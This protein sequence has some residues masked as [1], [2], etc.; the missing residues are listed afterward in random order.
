MGTEGM[1]FVHLHVHS[2]YS[3]M[4]GVSSPGAL[5]QA[6]KS[7]GLEVLA[8]TDT[9]GLYGLI[10]FLEA[11][12]R[13]GIRPV[14]GAHLKTR[15]QEAVVL[16]KTESGYPILSD[17]ISRI[18][19]QKDFLL[20]EGF[21]EAT[22]DLAVLS[23]DA[24]LLRSLRSKVE[25]WVEINPGPRGR[26]AMEV[27][28]ALQLPPLA[29]NAVYFAHPD[30][31]P[32]HRLVRA[33]DA[34]CT[35]STLPPH[36]TVQP[37]Q[38][39]KTPAEMANHLP[40]CPEAMANTARLASECQT[41]WDF[42]G[43]VFPIYEDRDEDHFQVLLEA[44]REG[45]R[46]RYGETGPAIEARLHEEL[47]LIRGKGYVDYFLVVADIVR[48]R[49]I[50]CGR[51]SGAASLV[52]YLLGITHVD[53]IRHHLL[54]GRFLNPQRKDPPDID[55][56]FPWDERDD[57][58]EE[59]R[60]HHGDE[61]FA[62][63]S[64]HVGFGARAAVREVA[65]VYGIPAAEIKEVTRRLSFWTDPQGIRDRME[66]HPKFQGFFLD[67]PW[68][69]V[70]EWASRLQNMPR[71]LSVHCGGI[72]LT[73]DPVSS[74]VPIER[75]RKGVRIIQW[76]K[77]QTESAGLVK[78]D[79]LGNRSLAV[80]RDTLEAVFRN[81]GKRI[82]YAT[83][84]PLE[85]PATIETLRD[86][87]TMGVF[88]VE[89]PAMRQ[90][91]KKTRRGDFE[92]LVIHSSIIRPAANRYINEYIHRLHGAP[93]EPLHPDLKELLAETYGILVY[94][95]D[96]VQ[97]SM[98]LAGFDWGEADGL[99]KVISRKSPEQLSDYKRRFFEGCSARGVSQGVSHTVWDMILSF[100]GYS[101]C[102]PHS[103]SYALVSFKSAYLKAHH[104]AEFMAAVISNGGGYY[105]TLAYISEARRMGLTVTGPDINASEWNASGKGD[106]IRLGLQQIQ[107][108]RRETVDAL[109]IERSRNG[110]FASLDDFLRRVPLTPSD[111]SLLVKSGSLDSLSGKRNRPQLLWLMDSRLLRGNAA[112]TKAGG[113]QMSLFAGSPR[114]API[115][116]LP[117][118]NDRQ[119]WRQ[120]ME[121]LGF[122]L[123]VHPITL[124][125]GW[126][127][128]IPR[129]VLQASNLVDHVGKTVWVIGWPIT[130]KEVV[131]RE[132]DP[133]EFVSFEDHTAI[134]ETVF[135]P[136]TF[137]RFCRD[138]TMDRPYLLYGEVQ[139]E[140]GTVSLNVSKLERAPSLPDMK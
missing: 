86:G 37:G 32:L 17:L 125:D 79:L 36:E 23:S 3:L 135:F 81:T 11:A 35:L 108:V 40:Y 126:I 87:K 121:T 39:L 89:S 74:H 44:C 50:H 53:P 25:C 54:F 134:Y 2:H 4:R 38:W 80:I 139:E 97:V 67:P 100:A 84:N 45:I 76:E 10:H 26:R 95:E 128:R 75:S 13:C 109:L 112:N 60:K 19:L 90:L 107:G 122:V 133:M 116:S 117:A 129:N 29:T 120:E 21:P 43:T 1:G 102:K 55:V 94:Q 110:P 124:W 123:S 114:N 65:K 72:I 41:A 42:S 5:C 61:R 111:G 52:S 62:A 127:R 113:R 132:G 96:V 9:N 33:I 27:A 15:S 14:L 83:F 63:V 56:D 51:G 106:A 46:W 34:N 30:D 88:Y 92:H 24:E 137:Q 78:I 93:Y 77:D 49:P 18:H 68:P 58:F 104:P 103:A 48:R 85:D 57:L 8:L 131:T 66:T 98:T 82:D 20:H 31:Y 22:R 71:H 6:A 118:L 47:A 99:R 101:F 16:V 69:E 119:R 73:P 136:G 70:M 105:S 115:P 12:T 130:R 7:K 138:L 91:Q 140:F 28:M 59:V 64:N